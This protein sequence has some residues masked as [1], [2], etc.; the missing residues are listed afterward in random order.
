MR[1]TDFCSPEKIWSSGLEFGM[2]VGLGFGL[3]Q[4]RLD[5]TGADGADVSVCLPKHSGNPFGF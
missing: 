1:S 4:A 3:V 5:H 2:A